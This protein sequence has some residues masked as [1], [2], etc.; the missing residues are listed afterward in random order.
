MRTTRKTSNVRAITADP[1]PETGLPCNL[2]AERF[3]LG[4]ILLNDEKNLAKATGLLPEDFTLERHRQIFRA[5]LHLHVNGDRVDRVTVAEELAKQGLLGG[6]GISFLLSLD[7]G[8]PDIPRLDAYTKILIE[9][10]TLRTIIFESQRIISEAALQIDT[11]SELL[12]SHIARMQELSQRGGLAQSIADIPLIAECGAV[13]VEYLHEPELPRGAVVAFTGDSGS[14]KSTLACFFAGTAAASGTPVLV[15]DRENPRAAVAERL[16]R[17]G[18][19]DGQLLKYAGGWLAS[20]VPSPG[21]ASVVAWVRACDPKPLVIV[22]SLAAFHGGDQN[23]AG[24][25]RAFMQ[26]CRTLADLGATVIIVHHDGKADSAR[27]YRGS[28]D[29]KAAVDQAFHVSNYGAE[30]KLGLVKLRP[31]KSRFGF[32]GELIYHYSDGHFVRGSG[33]HAR[34]P[35]SDQLMDLLRNNPGAGVREFEHV[36]V[37]AGIGRDQARAWLADAVVSGVVRREH[38]TRNQRRHFV[39]QEACR[40]AE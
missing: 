18:V 9:K 31:Y 3:I 2:D 29:F 30:G 7:S 40:D 6:D 15:L 25:M 4:S 21:S 23:D 10:S 1:L 38:G 5:M 16:T 26:Q 32:A 12:A 24:E 22:D 27:D 19:A 8:M 37:N 34:V 20:G 33:D 39:T 13:A 36:A 17:L 28:S 14:G 11:P 35:A